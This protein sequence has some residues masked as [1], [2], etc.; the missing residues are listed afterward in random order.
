MN[1][2]IYLGL[3]IAGVLAVMGLLDL[4]FTHLERRK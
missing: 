3:L 2:L 1:E 4:G